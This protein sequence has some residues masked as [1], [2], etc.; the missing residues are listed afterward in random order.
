MSGFLSRKVLLAG[1]RLPDAI[2][3]ETT[4]Q[5]LGTWKKRDIDVGAQDVQS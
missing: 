2:C 4:L 1:P 3:L 5:V